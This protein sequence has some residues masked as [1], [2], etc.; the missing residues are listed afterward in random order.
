MWSSRPWDVSFL[1]L[2]LYF[3]TK[4]FLGLCSGGDYFL[5]AIQKK[6]LKRTVGATP[7]ASR[8]A[9]IANTANNSGHSTMNYDCQY[10]CQWLVSVVIILL[11]LLPIS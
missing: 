7:C 4:S 8:S 3:F 5:G 11:I 10:W 1:G 2:H 6:L 9:N